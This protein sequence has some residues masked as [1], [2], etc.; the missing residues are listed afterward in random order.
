MGRVPA[1]GGGRHHPDVA[2]EPTISTAVDGQEARSMTRC[3][4]RVSESTGLANLSLSIVVRGRS[5][6]SG[7][8]CGEMLGFSR[9][10]RHSGA[11][12]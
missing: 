2:V 10:G 1:G 5:P 9:A 4:Q 11:S 6:A 8:L 12:C 3:F 7:L